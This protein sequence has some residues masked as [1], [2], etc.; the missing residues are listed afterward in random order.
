MRSKNVILA[1]LASV[2]TYLAIAGVSQNEKHA[3]AYTNEGVDRGQELGF[4]SRQ[5]VDQQVISIRGATGNDFNAGGS[6][7]CRD[8]NCSVHTNDG[9]GTEAWGASMTN[10]GARSGMVSAT[11]HVTGV[12]YQSTYTAG[13]NNRQCQ[14][15]FNTSGEYMNGSRE[16]SCYGDCD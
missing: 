3:F 11:N 5:N 2:G 8:G 10:N 13:P 16:N 1:V 9:E 12:S 7:R 15:N 4:Y 6:S 14:C